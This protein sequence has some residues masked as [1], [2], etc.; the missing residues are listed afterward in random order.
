MTY[1]VK[2]LLSSGS[3][4]TR[5]RALFPQQSNFERRS[6]CLQL[7]ATLEA[8]TKGKKQKK[9]KQKQKNAKDQD[10]C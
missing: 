4:P 6:L 9:Q 2:V 1:D 7:D 3:N 8:M 10:Y 5:A